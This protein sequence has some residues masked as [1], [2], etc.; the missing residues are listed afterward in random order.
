MANV[1]SNAVLSWTVMA[2]HLLSIACGEDSAHY[3]A[4]DEADRVYRLFDASL[5]IDLLTSIFSAARQDF[6]GGYFTTVRSLVQAE[7]F[8]SEIE[9]ASELLQSGY[10]VAAAVIAG[11]FLKPR[12]G[13]SVIAIRFHPARWIR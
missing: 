12:C 1:H 9:Q 8:S 5:R 7:L 13:N 10:K 2:K 3:R 4:F 11:I 6:D